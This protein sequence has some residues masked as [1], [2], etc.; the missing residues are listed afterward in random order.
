[1][2]INIPRTSNTPQKPKPQIIPIPS[3]Q[4]AEQV[5]KQDAETTLPST[6]PAN[7][8]PL[9]LQFNKEVCQQHLD[10]IAEHMET[11]AGKQGMNPYM[12]LERFLK[13]LYYRLEGLHPFTS[14]SQ[15][16]DGNYIQPEQTA[17]LQQEILSLPD[18][19]E[20][21]MV[22]IFKRRKL[23]EIKAKKQL[24]SGKP[25]ESTDKPV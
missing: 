15:D 2:A 11:F 20:P 14:T 7:T 1:M 22:N 8:P 24:E 18:N 19:E 25:I 17:A 21:T 23:C 13:P 10:K 6:T 16:P 5:L 4:V 9:S 3:G 12:W